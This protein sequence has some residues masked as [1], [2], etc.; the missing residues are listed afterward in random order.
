MID[1]GEC[2]RSKIRNWRWTR[3][4]GN[5][6]LSQSVE[7]KASVPGSDMRGGPC[8]IV[9][10]SWCALIPCN[11][12]RMPVP[13]GQLVRKEMSPTR[14]CDVPFLTDS[15]NPTIIMGTPLT[16]YRMTRA[17]HALLIKGDLSP[18]HPGSQRGPGG[19]PSFHCGGIHNTG[20]KYVSTMGV[21]N[22]LHELED[23]RPCPW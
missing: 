1:L 12:H 14:S 22:S 8:D 17:A 5:A 3:C 23:R 19:Y 21:Q 9:L 15:S 20:T 7:H 16:V 13:P 18:P 10:I 2:P 6:V 11:S 4:D